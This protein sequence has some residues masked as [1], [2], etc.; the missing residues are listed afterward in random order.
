MRNVG[1]G[2]QRTVGCLLGELCGG[3]RVAEREEEYEIA[4]HIPV[5]VVEVPREPVEELHDEHRVVLH[6]AVDG[7]DI[8]QRVVGG[9]PSPAL[10]QQLDH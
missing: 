6:Q 3:A 8:E 2:E 5:H 10:F 4:A 7:H 1:N 9:Q